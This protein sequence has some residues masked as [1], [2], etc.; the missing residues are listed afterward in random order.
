[1]LELV[2][3]ESSRVESL[4]MSELRNEYRP[5]YEYGILPV[6]TRI[7]ATFPNLRNLIAME[8]EF[9]DGPFIP[10]AFNLKILV[11]GASG[12][13]QKLDLASGTMS[14]DM[15]CSLSLV[16]LSTTY[17]LVLEEKE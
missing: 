1:V 10:E 9:P 13:M 7:G 11:T 4:R 15:L 6:V 16:T 8:L 17:N 12:S 3:S 2:F 14:F 5:H